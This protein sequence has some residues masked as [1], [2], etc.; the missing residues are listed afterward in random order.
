M[1]IYELEVTSHREHNVVCS[2]V[3]AQ[4]GHVVDEPFSLPVCVELCA[5]R[6]N[7]KGSLI[8]VGV[9]EVEISWGI[10]GISNHHEGEELS[11]LSEMVPL[12]S[13]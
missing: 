8:W 5:I 12:R 1:R 4:V 3:L 7:Y 2:E 13:P 10:V 9:K 11:S 6:V